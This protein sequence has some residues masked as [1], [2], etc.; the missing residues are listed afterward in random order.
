MPKEW[1]T[2]LQPIVVWA[3]GSVGEWLPQHVGQPIAENPYYMLEVHYNNFDENEIRRT[4]EVVDDSSGLTLHLTP[5]LRENE[6]GILITGIAVSPLHM[7][8]PRQG[9]YATAGYCSLGCTEKV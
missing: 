5:K 3:R 1:D 8:P 7:V 6:A 9:G 2:C 4:R